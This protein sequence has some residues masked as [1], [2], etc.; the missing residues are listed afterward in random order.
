MKR[1][2][3]LLLL[4]IS[5]KSFA[6]INFYGTSIFGEE[7]LIDESNEVLLFEKV[8]NHLQDSVSFLQSKIELLNINYSTAE[9]RQS[10]EYLNDFAAIKIYQGNIKEAIVLL[11]KLDESHPNEYPVNANLGVAY[12]LIGKIDSAY[13]YTEKSIRIN[14][15][16][17]EGTEWLH[18]LILK[19]N[20]K[21]KTDPAYFYSHYIT[22]EV[23]SLSGLPI[24]DFMKLKIDTSQGAPADIA[25]GWAVAQMLRAFEHQLQ[26]R[27]IFVK[28]TN[29]VVANLLFTLADFYTADVDYIA[30]RQIYLLAK[31]YDPKFAQ[32]CEIR[33]NA[34]DESLG[35]NKFPKESKSYSLSNSNTNPNV[36][37]AILALT[38]LGVSLIFIVKKK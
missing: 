33:I 26:E 24:K 13:Y 8:R 14:P 37:Y 35:K 23:I 11:K 10:L 29:T 22:D 38:I 12:E 32:L 2:L 20:D 19:A 3:I 31:K 36:F 16:S 28:P 25:K 27:V 34:I 4:A 7:V 1:T 17:H 30:A 18:L 15:N 9:R 6:C 21:V 5:F